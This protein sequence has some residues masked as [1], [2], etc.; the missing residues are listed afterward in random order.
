MTGLYKPT[1]ADRKVYKPMEV[2]IVTPCGDYE[3]AFK[4]TRAVVNLVAY[5]WMNGLKVYQMGGV[6]RMVIHWARNELA[7]TSLEKINEHTGRKFTHLLWLDDDHVFNADM[8]VYLARHNGLDCVSALYYGRAGRNLPVAYVKD[9]TD[10][11]YKHFPLLEVPETLVEVDAVGF[12]SLLMRLDVLE[13]ME[14]PYFSFNNCGEDI[15]FCVHAKERGIKIW[16]DGSYRIGHIG[17]PA[18]VSHKTYQQYLKDNK[19]RL[20]DRIKVPLGGNYDG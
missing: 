6:E 16:L 3:V 20:K 10:D 9:D 15:Y 14:Y 7:R 4:F 11:K 8:L 17:E 12:G 19:E 2:A 1:K 5:S 18:I 13:R